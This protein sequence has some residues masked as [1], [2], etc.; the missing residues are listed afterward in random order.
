[1]YFFFEYLTEIVIKYLASSH[2]NLENNDF[3]NLLL[4]SLTLINVCRVQ[5]VQFG[6]DTLT[7]SSKQTAFFTTALNEYL[8]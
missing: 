3:Y 7:L 5:E 1:M 6:L 8:N 2:L 4:S